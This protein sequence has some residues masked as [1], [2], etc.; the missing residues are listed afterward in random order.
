MSCRGT[1]GS[2]LLGRSGYRVP[3][4]SA[5]AK[6]HHGDH[7]RPRYQQRYAPKPGNMNA[8][9]RG[10]TFGGQFGKDMFAVITHIGIFVHLVAPGADGR[11]L[12]RFSGAAEL[13]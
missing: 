1:R 8:P 10:R 11:R 13:S 5:M 6:D 7:C 9:A 4:L 3:L 2:D 12:P